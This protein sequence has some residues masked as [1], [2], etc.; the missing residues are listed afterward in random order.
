MP[1]FSWP[2]LFFALALIFSLI[3]AA[4]QKF[5]L[6]VVT[7]I[8][9]VLACSFLF[10]K[11]HL[12]NKVTNTLFANAQCIDSAIAVQSRI[13]GVFPGYINVYKIPNNSIL[14]YQGNDKLVL[15]ELAKRYEFGING[16]EINI[17]KA[18]EI[19]EKIGG[20]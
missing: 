16:V 7:V 3:T 14:Q 6:S 11:E 9:L 5:W 1:G 17:D 15:I 19:K 20:K 8:F 18:N 13:E 10:Y 4:I 12:A 2:I